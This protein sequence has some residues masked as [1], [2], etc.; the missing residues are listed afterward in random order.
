MLQEAVGRMSSLM[1]R[2]NA[3]TASIRE[4]RELLVGRVSWLDYRLY[5]VRM[6][7]FH[8]PV[9]QV[10][11]AHRALSAVI[12]DAG[13]RNHKTA[14]LAHDL[15][16]LGADRRDLLQAPRMIL[17]GSLE[18][19]EALGWAYV[20]ESMTLRNKLIAQRLARHLPG[21][22]ERASAYLRCY[23]DEATTRWRELGSALD[24]FAQGRTPASQRAAQGTGHAPYAEHAC[25][26][27]ID[28]ARDGLLQLRRWLGPVLQPRTTQRVA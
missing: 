23:G 27:V 22:I 16:A 1:A 7:G 19:P 11:T 14:L 3:A 4:D 25:E 17:A 2:L 12:P 24:G 6:Y 8:A 15:V 21:E 20:V 9:E 18:L 5:L 10:L 28:A 26:R 13:L